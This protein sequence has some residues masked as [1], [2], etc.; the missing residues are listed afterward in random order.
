MAIL[1]QP[2]VQPDGFGGV[3][4]TVIS[5]LS[6]TVYFHWYA[7]GAWLGVT[8][9][10]SRTFHLETGD[11]LRLDVLDTTDPDFDPIANAPAG[12]PARRTLYW[13]RSTDADVAAYKI[14]QQREAA[15]FTTI[16]RVIADATS[17]T[18][19]F[20]TPRLDD[21][22]NYTWRITPIDAAG[23]LGTAITIGPEKIVRTPDAPRFT[24][25]WNSGTFKMTFAAAA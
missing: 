9:S 22:T 16:G 1:A 20:L 3:T 18:Y 4:V 21:L 23:N 25:T 15:A 11:Q 2:T 13:V 10:N 5:N 6:G 7:D 17:W 8:T 24:V 12:W 19:D 14:E